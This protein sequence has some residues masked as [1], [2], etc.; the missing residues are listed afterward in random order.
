M[1]AAAS[2]VP[3][4]VGSA[5]PQRRDWRVWFGLATTGL[6]IFMGFKY[7]DGVVGW[8]AFVGQPAEALGGFL[9][10]A[11]APL[12]FL[13]L[14]IG[15]FL[16]QREL[17]QNT[18]AIRD[19]YEQMRRAAE[20]AEVQA[21]AISANELH[22]RQE[23]FLMVA[24]RVSHQLGVTAGLLFMS[25]QAAGDEP[26][27]DRELASEYWRRLGLGDPEIFSRQLMALHY[28]LK[29]EG[30]SDHD[31][32]WETEIRTRHSNNFLKVFERMIRSAEG[33]DP[34][35]IIRDAILGSG[36]GQQYQIIKQSREA[37][38]AEA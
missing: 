10:G 5:R 19:Q 7:I 36:H 1:S 22:Q 12:A 23:T 9:E 37:G 11:F 27:I 20:H 16:Q 29:A 2:T 38:T 17:S 18:E 32:Y 13:W 6:W 14:V 34:D 35:G 30:L 26:N 15:F 31:L 33:C 4:A 21:R 25:S 8:E 24:D 28:S 3:A